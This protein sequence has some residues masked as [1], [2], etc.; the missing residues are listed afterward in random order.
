[1]TVA[2]SE[3]TRYV[4]EV[5]AALADLPPRVRDELLEDLPEHLAEVAADESGEGSL[6]DRLGPPAAY[7]AELRASAGV[8]AYRK[9]TAVESARAM[10]GA[11]RSRLR[12]ADT[13]V[14]PMIGYAKASD[15]L[16]LLS[17]AWW[18]LRGYLAAMVVTYATDSTGGEGLLP[19]VEGNELLGLLLLIACVVASIW[20]GRRTGRLARWPRNLVFGGSALLVLIALFWVEDVDRAA[21]NGNGYGGYSTVYSNPYEHISDVYVYDP[22]GRLLTGVRLF[23]QNGQPIQLG[24]TLCD[25]RA[26][27]P[28]VEVPPYPRCPES[29]PW[30]A[31]VPDATDPRAPAV[32]PAPP[33]PEP[34]GSRTA[35]PTGSPTAPPPPSPVV[36]P[37]PTAPPSPP[38]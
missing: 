29:A 3:I 22:E 2:Q 37:G 10:V 4:E 17:P 38:G 24:G 20:L 11:A 16:R 35:G 9:E 7:A 19:R 31:P 33:S 8:S 6:T 18:V 21:R 36:S 23:D 13:R 1:M 5:R 30:G 34:T 28:P 25:W 27:G 26:A 14:G 32:V 12:H 15:F